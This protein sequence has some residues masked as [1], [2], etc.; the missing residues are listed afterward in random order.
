VFGVISDSSNGTLAYT[1]L[2]TPFSNLRIC[3][4]SNNKKAERKLLPICTPVFEITR[5]H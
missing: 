5:I 1:V 4:L 3:I 2:N